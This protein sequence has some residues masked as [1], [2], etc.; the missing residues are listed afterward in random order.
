MITFQ[1]KVS[2]NTDPS[3]PEINKITDQNINDLKAGVNTNETNISNIKSAMAYSTTEIKTGKTWVDGKP[4]YRKTLT[5]NTGSA[6]VNAQYTILTDDNID[7]I[8]NAEGVCKNKTASS[9]AYILSFSDTMALVYDTAGSN[10]NKLVLFMN[11]S[12]AATFDYWITI[13]YTKT[14]DVAS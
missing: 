12:S 5:G 13:E 11:N 1:D 8:T 3:I 14:T 9:K 10:I 7:I 6:R 2:L 4:I